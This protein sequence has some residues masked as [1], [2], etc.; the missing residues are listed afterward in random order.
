M[1]NALARPGC[2]LIEVKLKRLPSE[3]VLEV[4]DNGQ[5]D[6]A[7]SSTLTW[8]KLL[9]DYYA[10]KRHAALTLQTSPDGGTVVRASFPAP[11]E[12]PEDAG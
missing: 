4:H 6:E 8:G 10:K 3:F 5:L 2:S 7:D 1:D 12:V 9:M 11:A